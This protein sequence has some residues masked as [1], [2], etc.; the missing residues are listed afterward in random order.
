LDKEGR[1]KVHDFVRE[2]LH[3]IESLCQDGSKIKLKYNRNLR[4]MD[5]KA[6]HKYIHFTLYKHGID[7]FNAIFRLSR[8]TYISEKLFSTAGLKDKRGYTTQ[9]VS[10]YNTDLQSLLKFYKE[11][12]RNK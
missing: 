10:L 4:K 12:Y 8:A 9:R 5:P 2:D 7:T 11:A 3:L 1:K 6:R